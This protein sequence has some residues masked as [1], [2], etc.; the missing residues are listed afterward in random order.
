MPQG[1]KWSDFLF[2]LDISELADCL[3]AK[4][5]PFGYADDV[6]LWYEIDEE[7]D[8]SMATAVINQDMKALL[9]W[10][11]DNGTTFEPEKMY[12]MV[13][14]HKHKINLFDASGL[15][16][17]GEELSI[18]DETTLVGLKIDNKMR[19]G[20]MAKDLATKARQRIGALSRVRHFLD[21]EIVRTSR[22]KTV[23]LMFIRSIMEYNSISWMGD[24]QSHLDKLDRVQHSAEKIGNFTVEP[25]QARRDAA[26]MSFALKLQDG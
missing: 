2:D 20:P 24:A 26:A 19:W 22:V 11:T 18:V 4:V 16:F 23:Y 14:S 9:D 25:L 6:A 10:S 5:I 17:N 3:S 13:I 1:G 8:H 7:Q 21:S 12:A 15:Y